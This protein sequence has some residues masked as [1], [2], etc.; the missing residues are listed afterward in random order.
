MLTKA[1][2]F[3]AVQATPVKASI[4]AAASQEAIACRCEQ[5]R[6]ALHSCTLLIKVA[7]LL[8]LLVQLALSC[9]LQDQVDLL[10]QHAIAVRYIAC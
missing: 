4:K 5:R 2:I 8:Q 3:L 1:C 6:Q 7:N 10:L 9:V